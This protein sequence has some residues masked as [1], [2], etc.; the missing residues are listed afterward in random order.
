MN[1]AG[2]LA[3]KGIVVTRPSAQAAG[4]AGAIEREGGAALRFPALEIRDLEDLQPLFTV[5]ERLESFD[6]AVFVS[7]NAVQKALDLVRVRCAAGWPRHLR[8]AAVGSGSRR[9]LERRGI[10]KVIA[11]SANADSEALLALPQ[12]EPLAGAKVVIFR[13]EGGR[14]LLGDALA[15]RGA[16]VEYAE[17]YRRA[18]PHTDCTALLTAW[19]RGAVHAV[20]VS[21]AAGLANFFDMIGEAGR[22]RLRRTP[23]FVP[24][25]RVAAEAARRGAGAVQIAGPGDAEVVS[26]LVAYFRDAK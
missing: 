14:E 8:V 3:G 22:E 11:P 19:A 16:M 24:H 17:C 13:G 5:L 2:A 7:P 6:L 21:S 4:L 10:G 23:L 20:T 12:L 18:R 25:Q 15:A 9:E 26:A 1:P